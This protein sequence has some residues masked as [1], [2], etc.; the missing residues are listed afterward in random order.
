M[1]ALCC[2][3]ASG[4]ASSVAEEISAAASQLTGEAKTNGEVY[5]NM[6][7]KA[8]AKVSP[9]DVWYDPAAHAALAKFVGCCSW[10]AQSSTAA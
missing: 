3:A 9:F 10:V 1:F 7:K 8:A 6:V 4:A 2:A 5:V